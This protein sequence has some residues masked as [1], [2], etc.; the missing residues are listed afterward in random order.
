VAKP[1]LPSWVRE[2]ADGLADGLRLVSSGNMANPRIAA[3]TDGRLWVCTL[4]GVAVIDELCHISP[5]IPVILASGYT[6]QSDRMESVQE[7]YEAVGFLA[8]PYHSEDLVNAAKELL[9]LAPAPGTISAIASNSRASPR[10]SKA[11][12]SSYPAST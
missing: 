5:S 3:S 12:S 4:D 11:C 10:A 9:N 6:S 1:P 8:K 2:D 7:R